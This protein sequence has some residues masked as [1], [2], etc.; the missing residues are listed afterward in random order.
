MPYTNI[1]NKH[2]DSGDYPASLPGSE[3]HDRLSMRKRR[4]LPKRDEKGRY[5]GI[6][7]ATYTEQSAH[8]TKVFAAWGLPLVLGFDQAHVKLTPDGAL[9]VKA[10]IHTIGQGLGDNA[11]SGRP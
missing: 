7:F 4:K 3:G 6:G 10:G 5:L 11:C 8:G 2:Y 1:T 9:E